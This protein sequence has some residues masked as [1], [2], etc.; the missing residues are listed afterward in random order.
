MVAIGLATACPAP[1]MADN[2][3]CPGAVPAGKGTSVNGKADSKYDVTSSSGLTPVS[4]DGKSFLA[5]F[6]DPY[7]TRAAGAFL[8][9]RQGGWVGPMAGTDTAAI[10]NALAKRPTQIPGATLSDG[11]RAIVSRGWSLVVFPCNPLS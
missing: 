1:A 7:A 4:P 9:D 11:A 2:N 5:A 8:Q 6:G 3:V 10:Q